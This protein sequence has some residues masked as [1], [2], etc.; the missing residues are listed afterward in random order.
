MKI[1][2][3]HLVLR[4]LFKSFKTFNRCCSGQSPSF[5]LP[6]TRGR[7]RGGGLNGLNGL[8]VLNWFNF[9][10]PYRNSGNHSV[11]PGQ[12]YIKTRQMHTIII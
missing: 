5:I 8:N 3:I 2:E 12:M 11:M 4:F 10:P 6:A 7:N 9:Y 1:G